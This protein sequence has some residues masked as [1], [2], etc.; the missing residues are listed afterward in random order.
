MTTK[1]PRK[2]TLAALIEQAAT[3]T[4]TVAMGDALTAI[5]TALPHNAAPPEAVRNALQTGIA[6]LATAD[7]EP[8]ETFLADARSLH[9]TLGDLRCRLEWLDALAA[10]IE[11]TL[12]NPGHLNEAAAMYRARTLAG[13][14]TYLAEDSES[15]ASTALED[16]PAS[17]LWPKA[18][19]A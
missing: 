3:A 6:R 8:A 19:A 4:D 18:G 11:S 17:K 2:P 5:V 15:V 7:A 13:L 1:T 12:T 14:A 10:T 9:D 16:V